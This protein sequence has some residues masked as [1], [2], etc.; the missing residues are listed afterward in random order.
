ME[1]MVKGLSRQVFNK[2]G[3]V[4]ELSVCNNCNEGDVLFFEVID[5]CSRYLLLEVGKSRT[6]GS[7]TTLRFSSF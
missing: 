2:C 5:V 3:S 1:S 7:I 4:N 6:S